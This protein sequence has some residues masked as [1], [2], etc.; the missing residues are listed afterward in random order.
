MSAVNVILKDGLG[1]DAYPMTVPENVI[2]LSQKVF[3]LAYPVGSVF[4]STT[5]TSSP[6]ELGISSGTWQRLSGRFLI[7]SGSNGDGATY[8]FDN[9]GGNKDAIVVSHSHD[10]VYIKVRTNK[11]GIGNDYGTSGNHIVTNT[12]ANG[13]GRVDMAYTN[14]V[15]S[16]GTDMNMPPYQV[17]SM[18]KRIG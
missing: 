6:A 17:V 10:N 9:T 11:A 1:N 14:T 15:G 8:T 3:D 12:G 2:G 16:S 13:Y 7:G 4:I 18:W 5:T